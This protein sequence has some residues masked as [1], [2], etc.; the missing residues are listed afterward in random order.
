M[1]LVDCPIMNITPGVRSA[2]TSEVVAVANSLKTGS[3]WNELSNLMVEID[4][5]EFQEFLKL[6]LKH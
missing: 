5:L 2:A 3:T 1:L 4:F 6:Q